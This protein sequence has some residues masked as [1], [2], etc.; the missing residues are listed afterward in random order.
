[1]RRAGLISTNP[2]HPRLL[3]AL[4]AGVTVDE[5]EATALEAVEHNPPKG[6]AW[7]IATAL[8]RRNDAAQGATHASSSTAS[9]R[10]LADQSAAAT[11]HRRS[12]E[13]DDAID[14]EATRVA[15]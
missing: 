7:A 9:R 11:R 3:E 12:P 15:R 4:D 6:F 5:L 10:S 13:P 14:G 2:G 8:G 1:M